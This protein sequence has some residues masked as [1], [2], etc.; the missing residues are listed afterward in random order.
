LAIVTKYGC[1]VFKKP[2]TSYGTNKNY[3]NE[4][5]KYNW[6]LSIDADELPDDELINSLHH[7]SLGNA[8]V[9]YDIPFRSYCGKQAVLYGNWG[10]EHHIRLFNRESVKWAETIVHENLILTENIKIEKLK[11]YIHHY[12]IKDVEEYDQKSKYYAKLCAQQYFKNGK[13][14]N[15]V[16]KRLS[17]VFGFIK[18][19][20]VLLGFL[21]GKTGWLI[22]KTNYINTRRKY[23]YLDRL[24]DCGQ[25]KHAVTESFA[26]EY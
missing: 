4:L 17:P 12:T 11:G 18:S 26:I 23:V 22:A 20:I 14:A 2:W 10:R 1:R 25:K 3:G 16:K 6:I 15:A 9:A 21:D 7:I 13:R 5:A 8:N 24:E 19:Y